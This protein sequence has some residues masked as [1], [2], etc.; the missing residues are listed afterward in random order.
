MTHDQSTAG[1]EITLKDVVI[2]IGGL[3]QDMENMG[4]NLSKKI[5]TVE[6]RLT[7]RMDSLETSLH[8]RMDTLETNLTE[9]MDS[10]EED[11][12]ATIKDTIVIRR[13]TGMPVPDDE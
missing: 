1:R 12:T 13:H 2:S 11:L 7:N 3:R 10:L 6:S 9:R 4:K 5:D 8:K